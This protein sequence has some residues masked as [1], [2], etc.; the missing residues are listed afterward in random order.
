MRISADEYYDAELQRRGTPSKPED[1]KKLAVAAIMVAVAAE[2]EHCIMVA[3][4]KLGDILRDE[5]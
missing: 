1:W 2:R 3:R 5:S 4:R